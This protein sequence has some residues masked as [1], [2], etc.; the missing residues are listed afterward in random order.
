M[1]KDPSSLIVDSSLFNYMNITQ[2]NFLKKEIPAVKRLARV[3]PKKIYKKQIDS[4]KRI[5]KIYDLLN[6]NLDLIITGDELASCILQADEIEKE[7]DSIL[8][9]LSV[10]DKESLIRFLN[11][12]NLE[13]MIDVQNYKIF[14]I[15]EKILKIITK[16]IGEFG[17]PVAK[18]LY[19]RIGLDPN[20]HLKDYAAHK[21]I[22]SIYQV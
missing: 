21:I 14:E 22:E 8:I 19:K 1:E 5:L 2:I 3:L 9:S 10:D 16:M 4:L 13:I 11:N 20:K 12:D 17:N 18:I 6:R 15:S 7:L